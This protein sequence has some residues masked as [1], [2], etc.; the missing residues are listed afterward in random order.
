M[1]LRS[2]HLRRRRKRSFGFLFLAALLAS[3]FA[4]AT[5]ASDARRGI[6]AALLRRIHA[7][8][9]KDLNAYMA[10]FT[11]N[12]ETVNVV[13]RV[14]TA[15]TLRRSMAAN[16]AAASG[17]GVGI[18]QS[19]L[20]QVIVTK[21]GALVKVD[22]RFR[23]PVVRTPTGPVYRYKDTMASEVWVRGP[24]GWQ[25]QREHYLFD[26]TGVSSKPIPLTGRIVPNF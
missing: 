10:T 21:M 22:T 4:M 8:Q 1:E 12:W 14:V 16:F 5:P 15:A 24:A 19:H 18:I 2:T 20:L 23:Y 26:T 9:V 6:Q 17:P 13:G 11:S 3:G 25:E 7:R